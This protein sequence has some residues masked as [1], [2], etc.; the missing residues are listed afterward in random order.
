MHRYSA[1]LSSVSLISWKKRSQ[2]IFHVLFWIDIRNIHIPSSSFLGGNSQEWL[3]LKMHTTFERPAEKLA[4]LGDLQVFW[5]VF[6]HE[7]N[8]QVAY[9]VLQ[10]QHLKYIHA[11]VN[12]LP[13][14][15]F[16]RHSLKTYP[17]TK[18]GL[19]SH[20]TRLPR[21]NPFLIAFSSAWG[22][23]QLFWCSPW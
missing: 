11:K 2:D 13:S 21:T 12:I 8:E 23:P 17:A 3:F 18:G 16:L 10:L 22:G 5:T 7:R 6:L 1:S 19:A 20:D 4:Y 15:L 9:G 14:K